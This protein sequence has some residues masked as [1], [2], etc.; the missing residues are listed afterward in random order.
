MNRLV[1]C[2]YQYNKNNLRLM[3]HRYLSHSTFDHSSTGTSHFS[4]EVVSFISSNFQFYIFPII[5]T[6]SLH[7]MVPHIQLFHQQRPHKKVSIKYPISTSII[8]SFFPSSSSSFP[9]EQLL[10]SQSALSASSITSRQAVS[11]TFI[12]IDPI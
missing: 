10:L 7:S 9:S 1:V 4:Q 8:H 3:I 12:Y 5:Y 2:F 11:Q 6:P